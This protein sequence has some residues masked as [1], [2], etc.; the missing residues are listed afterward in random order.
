MSVADEGS[1][2]CWLSQGDYYDAFSLIV[3]LHTVIGLS[4]F[5]SMDEKFPCLEGLWEDLGRI[6]D[7][8][9]RAIIR[10]EVAFPNVLSHEVNCS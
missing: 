4:N 9:I 8:K 1:F 6:E 10:Y 3:V 7:Q 2:V 5:V